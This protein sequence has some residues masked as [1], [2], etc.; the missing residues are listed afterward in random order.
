M[1]DLKLPTL[2]DH[3]R[4]FWPVV[5]IVVSLAAQWAILGQR[6]NSLEDQVDTNSIAI[7]ELRSQVQESQKDYAALNQKVDSIAESVN[8]IRN[9]I[10]T[11][12]S[13]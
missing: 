9:R 10:D 12:L 11:A 5:L 3:F 4:T 1:S 13:K 6:V 8:Y 2:S 7:V